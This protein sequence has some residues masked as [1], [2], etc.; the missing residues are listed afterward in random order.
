MA[1]ELFGNEILVDVTFKEHDFFFIVVGT[2]FEIITYFI[3]NLSECELV[4]F[5]NKHLLKVFKKS[6]FPVG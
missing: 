6:G 3:K 4:I 1:Q 5:E 2:L